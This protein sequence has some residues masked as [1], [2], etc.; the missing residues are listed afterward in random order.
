[1]S[2]ANFH[3]PKAANRSGLTQA[4]AAIGGVLEEATASIFLGVVSGVLTSVLLYFAVFLIKIHFL[5]WYQSITY[6][7]VDIGGIWTTEIE[8]QEV[9]AKMEM[10]LEQ[11]GHKL[12]GNVTVIQGKDLSNPSTITNLELNGLLWEGFATLNMKSM[13]RTRLSFA[14]SLLA[15]LNGG[16]TLEGVYVYRSIQSD[17][18]RSVE[19][20]WRR[21]KGS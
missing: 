18:I 4:L 17:E 14:T 19:T 7:G 5:P 8:S 20:R 15:V 13:D 16:R 11:K 10:F 2:S 1:M 9:K 3:S 6:R 12:C 21:K